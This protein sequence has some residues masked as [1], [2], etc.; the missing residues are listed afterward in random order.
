MATWIIAS[1]TSIR[2]SQSRTR[3]AKAGHPTESAFDHPAT[4]EQLEARFGVDA[5]PFPVRQLGRVA[6]R[7]LLDCSHLA[8]RLCCPHPQ[9]GGVDSPNLV[10]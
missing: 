2:C 7:S 5:L 9:L 1:E 3:R 10:V 6:L 8:A 4:V